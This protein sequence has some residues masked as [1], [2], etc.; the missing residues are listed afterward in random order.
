VVLVKN[1]SGGA[2]DQYAVL[3]ITGAL[4]D[5]S[6]EASEFKRRAAFIGSTPAS[7]QEDKFVI[8]LRDLA[9]GAIGPALAEG[10]G[11][12]QVNITSS[13]HG[14]AQA[15][16][17]DS[18]KLASAASG[19]CQ[20]LHAPSGTGTKD[21]LVRLG[22]GAGGGGE[23]GP[24]TLLSDTHTDTDPADVQV[25][26][27]IVGVAGGG[28]GAMWQRLNSGG[29]SNKYKGLF[30]DTTGLWHVDVARARSSP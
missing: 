21:C 25:G 8:L 6:T 14:F 22:G 1:N 11:Y 20:I 28:G 2:L 17:G 7:G 26:D 29:S 3:G 10:V 15:A 24:H 27:V 23:G 4:F 5:P 9:A 30:I 19:Q 13:A 12:V 18:A 16:A